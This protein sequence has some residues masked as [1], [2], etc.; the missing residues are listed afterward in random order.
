M[1]GIG[2]HVSKV[3]QAQKVKGHMFS[4]ICG[5]LLRATSSSEH[6]CPILFEVLIWPS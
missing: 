6:L 4:L 1:D 3:S 2:E 5:A